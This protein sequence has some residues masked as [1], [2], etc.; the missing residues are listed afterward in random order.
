MR[1]ALTPLSKLAERTGVAVLLVRHLNKN[2]DSSN[3]KHRGGGSI[4]I[5]G[6]CRSALLAVEDSDCNVLAVSKCNL[7]PP[8]PSLKYSLV[9]LAPKVSG[10]EWGGV[11]TRTASELLAA[12]QADE[13]PIDDAL[14]FLREGL[15]GGPVRAREMQQNAKVLGISGRTLKRARAKLGVRTDKIGIGKDSHWEWSLTPTPGTEGQVS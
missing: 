1:R 14:E 15:S 13:S 5:I 9:E 3:A 12:S 6:A 2:T 10:V 4:G 8:A 11:S 7:A